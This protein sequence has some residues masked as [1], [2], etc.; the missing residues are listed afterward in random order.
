MYEGK[1]MYSI[2]YLLICEDVVKAGNEQTIILNP[3]NLIEVDELPA[4]I[5]LKLGASL[6]ADIR[7]ISLPY[8]KVEIKTVFKN[9]ED[10]VIFESN[11]QAFAEPPVGADE[12]KSYSFV[13][14]SVTMMFKDV[15]FKETGLHKV[16]VLI[17]EE[18]K[19]ELIFPVFE[20]VKS[21]ESDE[22]GE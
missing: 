8:P 20:K 5:T 3:T 12:A 2:G 22:N 7:E 14:A 11:G 10:E 6:I 17:N 16:E 9:P 13:T 1:P 18:L 19:K 21:I 4:K 15:E